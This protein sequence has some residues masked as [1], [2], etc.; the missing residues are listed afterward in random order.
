MTLLA[1]FVDITAEWRAVFPQH[2]TWR[3]A[4]RQSLGALVCLGRRCLTRIIWTH[5]GQSRSWSAEYF[6]HSRCQWDPQ[7]LFAPILSRGLAYCPG[8]LVGVAV[9][10]TRLRK[11]GRSIR[12]A[13]YQRDPLSP[14]FH[15]NLVLGLRFLQASLLVPLHRRAAV[16]TRGLPIRFEEVSRVK[17]PPRKATPDEVREYKSAQKLYNLSQRFVQTLT[18]L[19]EALDAAGGRAKTLVVAGDGSFCTPSATGPS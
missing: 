3:R 13:F 15:V 1:A 11:T 2:R 17:K 19:R 16:G 12:Q 6:L 5:G 14:P 9:D 4:V 7:A 18:Q 8:R 10:D